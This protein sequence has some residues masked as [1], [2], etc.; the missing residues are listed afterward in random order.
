MKWFENDEIDVVILKFDAGLNVFSGARGSS[1]PW[2]GVENKYP[3]AALLK[4]LLSM[5]KS[6]ESVELEK[7]IKV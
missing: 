1:N 7:G 2:E 6:T 4:V 5:L 3:S